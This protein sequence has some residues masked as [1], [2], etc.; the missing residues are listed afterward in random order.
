MKTEESEAIRIVSEKIREGRRKRRRRPN[1]RWLDEMK[2]DMR[3][4]DM[5]VDN[6]KDRD[7]LRFRTQVAYP[8]I[9]GIR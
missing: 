1:K 9:L 8:L 7:D 4:A 3:I 2:K 5:N 6:V